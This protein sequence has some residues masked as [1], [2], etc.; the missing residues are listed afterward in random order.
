MWP[1][2]LKPLWP[3]AIFIHQLRLTSPLLSMIF[4]QRR[5]LVWIKKTFIFVLTRSS[6][7]SSSGPS[8]MVYNFCNVVLSL[9]TMLISLILFLKYASTS[10]VVMFLHQYHA[11][12]LHCDKWLWKNKLKVFDPITIREVIYQLIT[13]TFAIQFKDTFVE[14]F[15]PRQFGVATLGKCEMV[16]HGVKAMLDLHLEWVVLQVDV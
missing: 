16:V 9:M 6:H 1:H 8:S 10:F 12:L 7:L 13:Y 14:H 2:Q 11:Y 15:S 4:I 5:I 3:F